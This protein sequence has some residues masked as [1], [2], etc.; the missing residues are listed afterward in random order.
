MEILGRGNR[1]NIPL[2][3]NI[4]FHLKTA[5]IGSDVGCQT[6]QYVVLLLIK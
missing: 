3:K 1:R 6:Y 4:F 2:L 5:G